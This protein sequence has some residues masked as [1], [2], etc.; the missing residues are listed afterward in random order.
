[1][2]FLQGKCAPRVHPNGFIQLDLDAQ[3]RLHVWH[4]RLGIRQD[5]Y[6]PVHDHIFGFE[7]FIYSGR[8]VHVAYLRGR[9]VAP[10][11]ERW[12]VAHA[13][14]GETTVLARVE[15]EDPCVLVAT[16]TTVCQA[17]E[18]YGFV[19]YRLHE[20]LSNEPT[21][22][23]MRKVPFSGMRAGTNC[24][25]ASVMVPI[26]QAPDNDFNR[27]AFDAERLWTFVEEAYPR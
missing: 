9:S 3:H 14:A 2:A 4:P 15:G 6:S 8:L 13:A 25:G 21:L 10:T 7:S 23:I 16:D 12:R 24:E 20:T 5:S 27:E 22:T 1:M 11:H 17:G 18:R 26:G 19:A